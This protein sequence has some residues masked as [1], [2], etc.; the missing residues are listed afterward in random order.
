MGN[1]R[2]WGGSLPTSWHK[3]SLSL[4]KKILQRMRNL[5]I[6]P[7]LP[8]FAGHLPRAIKR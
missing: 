3:R 1:I 4:Q 7:V 6:I 2:G 8:A 5:G